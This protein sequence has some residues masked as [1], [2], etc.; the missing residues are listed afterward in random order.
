MN[1]Y[2]SHLESIAT[3]KTL[4]HWAYAMG[5]I[6][7]E[8]AHDI[9]TSEQYKVLFELLSLKRERLLCIKS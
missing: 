5:Y 3:I 7:A 2:Q 4:E 9:L 6:T 1:T 8:Y